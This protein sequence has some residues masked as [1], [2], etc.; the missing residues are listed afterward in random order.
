MKNSAYSLRF[1]WLI[2]GE[3]W[4]DWHIADPGLNTTGSLFFF[5]WGSKR[6]HLFLKSEAAFLVFPYIFQRKANDI[7]RRRVI[8]WHVNDPEDK[9]VSQTE[10]G[11]L[12][13][14]RVS[15]T[16][17]LTESQPSA[18]RWP[19]RTAHP[20][21]WVKPCLCEVTQRHTYT[22]GS[23]RSDITARRQWNRG[24]SWSL[25]YAF[26]TLQSITQS[27]VTAGWWL[28]SFS[29]CLSL[30][31]ISHNICRTKIRF[32][33]TAETLPQV[34][35]CSVFIQAPGWLCGLVSISTNV[36]LIHLLL[37]LFQPQDIC[38]QPG[39]LK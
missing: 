11:H 6:A 38:A 29:T 26:F 27:A 23:S 10:R 39:K 9:V 5:I 4:N 28:M 20:C 22:T 33:N 12:F 25:T 19:P 21:C 3:L 2:S 24:S 7:H 13:Y 35:C 36:P 15:M 37:A 32:S 1:F 31:A 17:M 14:S 18:V 34:T 30:R 8:T 16:Q